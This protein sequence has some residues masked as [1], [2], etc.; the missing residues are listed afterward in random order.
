LTL[1]HVMKILPHTIP[2]SL[3]E[4]RGRQR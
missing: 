3:D 1:F 4:N 2:H